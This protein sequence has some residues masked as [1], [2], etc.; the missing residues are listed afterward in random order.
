MFLREF[1]GP[2]RSGK[3]TGIPSRPNETAAQPVT[4]RRVSRSAAPWGKAL[5]VLVPTIW[6]AGLAIGFETALVLLAL[7]AFGAAVIG[8]KRPIVGLLG[9][10]MLCTLDS[11]SRLFLLTGGLWRYNTFNYW[12]LI[13]MLLS[14]PFLLQLHDTQTRLLELLLIL[15]AVELL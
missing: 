12:L 9:V 8:L 4:Q 1:S 7:V 3:G 13:V 2:S 5:A 15:L 11:V 6:A 10:S 14:I